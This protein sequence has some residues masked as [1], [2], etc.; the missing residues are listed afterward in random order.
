M[1]GSRRRGHGK[2]LRARPEL[3]R[4]FQL[5]ADRG[6]MPAEFL[7]RVTS[8]ELS[9][10]AAYERVAGPQGSDRDDWRFAWLAL[11]IV[12][13]A[14]VKELEAK[15]LYTDLIMTL[16]DVMKPSDDDELSHGSAGRRIQSPNRLPIKARIR[17]TRNK[18]RQA[19]RLD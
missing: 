15:W 2:K 6:M 1:D 10:L 9:W 17:I 12:R 5:A 13:A 4:Y 3:E 11:W 14:G 19:A 16:R 18:K 7:G 8:R